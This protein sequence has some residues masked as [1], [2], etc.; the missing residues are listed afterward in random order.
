V[1]APSLV[2]FDCDGVLVDS[3]RLAVAVEARVLA[4]LGWPL[5]EEQ[6]IDRFV[7]RSPQEMVRQVE[8]EL[9]RPVSFEDDFE[10][11]YR[12]AF[13][14][15]L[16][17]V[18]GVLEALGRIDSLTCVASSSGHDRIRYCLGL[19]GLWS[20]FEGRV[21]SAE[22][23][24]RGKPAPDLFLHAADVMGVEPRACVVIED[25]VSGVHAARDAGMAV[26]GYSGSVTAAGA[27]AA[28]GARTFDDMAELPEL[29]RTLSP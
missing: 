2:V 18:P 5:S 23:V 17:P 4:Q 3:E 13:E 15:D 7:G 16:R 11:H 6:I 14:R 28:A 12:D 24:E 29:V 8:A 21:F 1:S 25:A 10:P 27:L 22:D 20:W 19:T 26:L 9:G